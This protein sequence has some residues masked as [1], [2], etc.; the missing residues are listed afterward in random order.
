[1]K[2]L[3]TN[4]VLRIFDRSDERQ[5]LAV[6]RLLA[7]GDKE[8]L[9]NPVVLSEVAWTLKRR[10]KK[11]RTVIADHLERLVQSPEFSVTFAD[12]AMEAVRRYRTGPADFADY[13]LGAINRALGCTTT[14]TFDEEAAKDQ[15]F[16]LMKV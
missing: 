5:S 15:S 7:E 8:F 6:E 13:F 16:S 3:D 12:E 11:S 4:I 10:Y 2:G 9:L 1:V 14:L